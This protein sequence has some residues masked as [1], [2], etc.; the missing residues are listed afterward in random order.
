MCGLSKFS[1]L[2]K[3]LTGIQHSIVK[4]IVTFLHKCINSYRNH[5]PDAQYRL[6]RNIHLSVLQ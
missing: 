5:L 3:N 4:Y 6:P 2:G 1:I